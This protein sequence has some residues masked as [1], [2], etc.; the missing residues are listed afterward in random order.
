MLNQLLETSR[1][2]FFKII[3]LSILLFLFSMLASVTRASTN[4]KIVKLTQEEL[5][6]WDSSHSI[7]P[8]K[9]CHH[10]GLELG[11]EQ[12]FVTLEGIGIFSVHNVFDANP[13]RLVFGI[14]N[15]KN[16]GKKYELP[17]KQMDKNTWEGSTTIYG[18]QKTQD[19]K[20]EIQDQKNMINIKM[21][22]ESITFKNK[23]YQEIK[24][25]CIP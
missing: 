8:K 13:Q 3:A 17:L 19:I 5:S 15:S 10:V 11:P 22:S 1:F 9:K 21:L 20:F 6:S 4:P 7:P 25:H 2:Y 16:E 14:V 24:F 23:N 12:N 18:A